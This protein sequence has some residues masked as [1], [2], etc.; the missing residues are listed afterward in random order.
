MARYDF[1]RI[2]DRR[3][4]ASYKWDQLT[5]LFG[6]ED[7]LPLWVAD[8][9]FPCAEPIVEAVTRRAESGIYGYTIRTEEWFEAILGWYGRRHGWTIAKDSI[10]MSPSVVTSLSLSVELFSEPGSGVIL[11]S[12]VYYPFYD[13]IRSNGRT[14][15]K[16]GLR[17]TDEGKYE[18]DF[19][20]LESFM[21][22]GAKLMLLCNPHNP[23]GRVWTREELGTLAELS[24]K[25]GVVVVSDEIHGD[26]TFAPH[27][28]TPYAAVSEAAASKSITLLAP[29]KTFNMPGIGSSFAVI[30]DDAMRG[31]F[32]KRIKA[33]AL[34][35]QNHFSH[36]ATIAAY[37][38]G[39]DWLDQLLPYIQANI[40]F[41]ISYL[42]SNAPALRPMRP[43]GTYLLW[44]DARAL[45]LS[46][47]E[48][49]RFMNADAKVA[50]NE[51]SM[52]GDEA[53]G[54]VRINCACPRSI[55]EEALRRFCAAVASRASGAP[56]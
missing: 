56:Q 3:N 49:K 53:V 52:F 33:L 18:M 8:M 30:P 24:A 35:M 20:G 41:A 34:H 6:G 10:V 40:D 31:K 15:L 2:M 54:F 29:T 11:Q 55:L 48:M 36:F 25:Y 51:G 38:Q 19:D 43:E 4:T 5:A 37:T 23:G 39:D 21:K 14:V 45:G 7:V 26:L 12:P 47:A 13:V 46:P 17:L 1:D 50:F 9:D 32:D 16:N 42:E 28:Y 22:D 27:R 44:V